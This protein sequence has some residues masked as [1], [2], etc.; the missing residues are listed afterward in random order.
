LSFESLD[1]ALRAGLEVI[2]I[3]E[4]REVA[5]MPLPIA[6]G[7]HVPLATLLHGAAAL[8]PTA[9]ILLVCARGARSLA[10]AHELRGRGLASVY[11]LRGGVL[12]LVART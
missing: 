4:A 3:R 9:R 5:E 10:A 1:E 12:G 6:A 7:R 2:D 11:S 8:A